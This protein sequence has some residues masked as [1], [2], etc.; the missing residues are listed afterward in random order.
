MIYR[1]GLNPGPGLNPRHPDPKSVTPD[2]IRG[3]FLT[4]CLH[5]QQK[6]IPAFARMTGIKTE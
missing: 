6:W 5:Q 2:L 4:P 1:P 3:P